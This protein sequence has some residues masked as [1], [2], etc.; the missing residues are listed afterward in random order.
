MPLD[1]VE[2]P[3][4][5]GPA[6]SPRADRSLGDTGSGPEPRGSAGSRL[7]GR[8]LSDLRRN[9]IA[10]AQVLMDSAAPSQPL[11]MTADTPLPSWCPKSGQLLDALVRAFRLDDEVVGGVE[12]AKALDRTQRTVKDYFAGKW[13]GADQRAVICR[14][15]ASALLNSG[16]VGAIE[17]PRIGDAPPPEIDDVLAVALVDLLALWDQEFN[18][19]ANLWPDVDRG[20]AAIVLARPVVVDLA[21]RWTSA[22]LLR[23]EPAPDAAP[24]AEQGGGASIMRALLDEHLPGVSV[25]AC[26]VEIGV[27]SRTVEHWLQK[28]KPVIPSEKNFASIATALAKRGRASE[29]D[30]LV[31]LRR[32]YGA[33]A[34]LREVA[35]ISNWRLASRL[36][37]GLVALTRGAMADFG[38]GEL[39]DEFRGN[40]ILS[41]RLGILFPSSAVVLDERLT[42]GL[43]PFW[44]DTVLALRDRRLTEHLSRCLRILGSLGSGPPPDLPV[45]EG[46]SVEEKRAVYEAFV[47]HLMNDNRATPER[48]AAAQAA[49]KVVY[50]IPAQNDQTRIANQVQQ[51]ENCMARRDFKG[52]VPHRARVVGLDPTNARYRF[53]FGATLWQA[54]EWDRALEELRESCRLDP[55]WDRPFVEIAIVWLNRGMPD[56]ALFHLRSRGN[57][58]RARSDHFNAHE[59][60]ALL[61]LMKVDD[62][63]VAFE[64]A[65]ALNPNHGLAFDRAAECA[66]LL[67]DTVKCRRYAKRAY[68]LGS[69][70]SHR[71][72]LS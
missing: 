55:G 62:A 2:R 49:G 4:T 38:E 70:D 11:N 3:P 26:A 65:V 16:I 9:R 32:S 20:L 71:K 58:F 61:L 7:A 60:I 25:D 66:F 21:L 43:D 64:R 17:V 44:H 47:L 40:H 45:F 29:G 36:G 67:G 24:W 63:L 56:Q 54:G 28:S 39:T 23:E 51:A 8:G 59:G 5:E 22:L 37:E 35:T 46:C 1:G 52:A 15:V 30:L 33:F 42:H 69:F 57:E 13:V 72:Y 50:R 6:A 41:L 48:I 12:P 68:D 31:Y 19:A 14:A 18:A 53:S 10:T 27:D 34:L